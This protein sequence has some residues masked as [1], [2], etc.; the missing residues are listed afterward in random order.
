MG[1]SGSQPAP[2]L[3]LNLMPDLYGVFFFV[4]RVEHISFA[5]IS[6][7]WTSY[8]S[9]SQVKV[10]V[11][12]KYEIER[13]PIK[14]EQS[15]EFLHLLWIETRLQLDCFRFE[16]WMFPLPFSFLAGFSSCEL[17]CNMKQKGNSNW[18]QIYIVTEITINF[19]LSAQKRGKKNASPQKAY[20]MVELDVYP[21]RYLMCT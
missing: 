3:A 2:C 4:S 19:R 14:A 13:Q 15:F 16:G 5:L 21:A 8:L 10:L 18:F 9:W 1:I 6:G 11:C 7:I 12:V 20:G 17:S